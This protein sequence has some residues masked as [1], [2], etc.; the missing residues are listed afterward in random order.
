MY[1]KNK[2]YEAN[3]ENGHAKIRPIHCES[4]YD[5]KTERTPFE[6]EYDNIF[7]GGDS[8]LFTNGNSCTACC[9]Q[10]VSHFTSL[11]KIV[12]YVQTCT[13]DQSAFEYPI[14]FDEEANLYHILKNKIVKRGF[15]QYK[16]IQNI[17]NAEFLEK[18]KSSLLIDNLPIV[19][20]HTETYVKL[21]F[22]YCVE[23]EKAFVEMSRGCC[24]DIIQSNN[25]RMEKSMFIDEIKKYGETMGFEKMNA[26]YDTD[27]FTQTMINFNTMNVVCT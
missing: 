19:S 13:H 9:Y 25:E 20:D 11:H 3:Y 17:K 8:I 4:E 15:Y 23:P 21:P 24:G 14:A 27:G 6:L 22:S 5:P 7:I 10:I 18:Y 1:W 16:D 2:Y 26:S 12:E